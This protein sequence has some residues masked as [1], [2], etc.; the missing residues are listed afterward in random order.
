[1]SSKKDMDPRQGLGFLG[2]GLFMWLLPTMAPDW[3]PSPAFGGMNGREMWLDGMGLV[4]MFLGMGVIFRYRLW[5]AVTHWAT[6]AK[7]SAPVPVFAHAKARR[8]GLRTAPV[9]GNLPAV[10][11]SA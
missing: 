8:T 7:P 5:P 11:R 4:Q 6:T 2:I 10:L 3:F 9:R 1:M